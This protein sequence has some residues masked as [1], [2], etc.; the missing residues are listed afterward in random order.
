MISR[1]QDLAC[2]YSLPVGKGYFLTLSSGSR[3]CLGQHFAE[4]TLFLGT[5]PDCRPRDQM[6]MGE[7]ISS[8]VWAFDCEAPLNASGKKVLPS[9]DPLDWGAFLAS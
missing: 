3:K 2:K 5:Y 8:I 7:V 1:T 9:L 4:Q 6:L